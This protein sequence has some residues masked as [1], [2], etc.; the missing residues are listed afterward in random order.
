MANITFLQ[1]K[2]YFA[3]YIG[4]NDYTSIESVAT[5]LLNDAMRTI[6]SFYPFRMNH[7]SGD[8][9]VS[10]GVGSLPTDLDF[11]HIGKIKVYKYTATTKYEY[12]RVDTDEIDKYDSSDYV[13]A[14]D[15]E[16]E[17]I[18]LTADTTVTIDHYVVPADLSA[19]DDTINFP[20]P[21]AIARMAAGQFWQS[22]EE[23]PD[24]AKMNLSVADNL[25]NQA[26]IREKRG[27]PYRKARPYG[28]RK[29]G[30]NK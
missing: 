21:E 25:V 18:Q 30:Y 5:G 22:F 13:Y 7:Q 19:D 27:V 8:V 2:N 4:E 14:I 28:G 23:D 10:S 17:E 3:R 15:M 12:N 6:S 16:N 20:I 11:S 1:L 24:Q 29:L 9:E 26:V